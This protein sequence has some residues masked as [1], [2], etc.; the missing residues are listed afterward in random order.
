[1][2]FFLK[3]RQK[4]LFSKKPISKLRRTVG[5]VLLAGALFAEGIIVADDGY[6]RDFER[7]NITMNYGIS[8]INNFIGKT[9]EVYPIRTLYVTV[10]ADEELIAKYKSKGACFDSLERIVC[11]VSQEY[12]KEFG[13]EFVI[14]DY[15]I[16]E[17]DNRLMSIEDRYEDARDKVERAHTSIKLL[18]SAQETRDEYVG[19]ARFYGNSAFVVMRENNE[20]NRQLLAHEIGHIFGAE[21]VRDITSVM[22]P[23]MPYP[24]VKNILW[25]EATKKIIMRNKYQLFI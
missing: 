4:N 22:Y 20:K 1:M 6:N 19:M 18:F 24:L 11:D 10:A 16:Y 23:E 5:A 17:S 14:G 9:N 15:A 2:S 13:I 12:K 25:N 21:H 8:I 7:T 3:K